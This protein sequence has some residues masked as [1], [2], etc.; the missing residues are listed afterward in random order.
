M[1]AIYLRKS[2][3]DD[4]HDTIEQTLSRHESILYDLANRMQITINKDHV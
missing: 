2:R 1:Y 4:P 3:N